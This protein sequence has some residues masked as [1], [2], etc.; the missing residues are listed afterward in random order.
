MTYRLL[1]YNTTGTRSVWDECGRYGSH[2][3]ADTAKAKRLEVHK[4]TE[5]TGLLW[6]RIESLNTYYQVNVHDPDDFEVKAVI[7]TWPTYEIA[8]WELEYERS[9]SKYPA[10]CFWISEIEQ[11][12]V[13]ANA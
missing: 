10:E 13:I 8:L 2:N 5:Q 1:E 4:E 3:D 12:E 6:H 11:W 7:D 9:V